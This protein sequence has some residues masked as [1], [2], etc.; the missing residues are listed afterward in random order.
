MADEITIKIKATDDASSK[1][2]EVAGAVAGIGTASD[3]SSGFVDKL[4]EHWEQVG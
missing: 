2:N 4:K 3:T 1:I